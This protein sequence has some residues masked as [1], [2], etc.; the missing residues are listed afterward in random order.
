MSGDLVGRLRGYLSCFVREG[1]MAF[2]GLADDV[3]E[4]ADR[5]EY[6][7]AQLSEAVAGERRIIVWLRAIADEFPTHPLL[8]F[9]GDPFTD[10]SQRLAHHLADAIERGHHVS[11][12][13]ER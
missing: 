5:I 2:A 3:A 6:L 1:D 9:I 4:A 10:D 11:N 8:T 12:G 13:V 7:E